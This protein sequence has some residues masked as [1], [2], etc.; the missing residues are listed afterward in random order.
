MALLECFLLHNLGKVN[1]ANGFLKN[2]KRL[3]LSVAMVLHDTFAI[4]TSLNP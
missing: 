4:Q 1:V 3:I 2:H